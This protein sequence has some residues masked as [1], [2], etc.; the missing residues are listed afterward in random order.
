ML[1]GCIADDFTGAG[2]IANTLS[3]G[4]MRTRL[5]VGDGAIDGADCD[6]GVVA[7]KTRSIAPGDAVAQSLAALDRLRAAGAAQIIFKYCSTFDSTPQGNIGPV[8]EALAEALGAAGVIVCPAFPRNGRT[9]YQGHLFVGDALLSESGMAHH[10]LTPMTDPDIRRWLAAQTHMSVGHVDL[11]VV[12][13]GS[14]AIEAALAQAEAG[15]V[16]VD[17]VDED[18]LR[19]IGH[20]ARKHRLV[21]GGS[22]VAL[23]LPAN[24]REAG[25]MKTGTASFTGCPGPALI[26]SGSCSTA[27][28]AQVAAYRLTAPCYEIDVGRLLA[29]EPLLG[30]IEHFLEGHL[31]AAP[32]IFSSADPA[33][34]AATQERYGPDRSAAAVE[35]LFGVIARTAV[36]RGTR[37]IVVAGGETSG[38]VVS[39]LGIA[40]FDLGPE[41]DPGIPA[42][43]AGPNLAL[44]LKSGNFG[45]PDFFARALDV[46]GGHHG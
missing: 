23:G 36:A 6:A 34:V 24:F 33:M 20:A 7:L 5:F 9:V 40:A 8:A 14:E 28:R 22:G 35:A 44:A 3:T 21:T 39:A 46:L 16:V 13:L 19:A 2:D 26:L 10:P 15:F 32:M 45:A 4:G 17:A 38:A 25:A 1:L 43:A 18:D 37:R 42:L 12:R 41:I 11:G 31:D 30:E 27:T 29:G